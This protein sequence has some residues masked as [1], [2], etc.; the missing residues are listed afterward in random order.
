MPQKT[1]LIT[2]CSKGG[3]GEAM[4]KAYQARG[5]RVFATLRNK[6]KGKS[7]EGLQ[8]IEILELDVTSEES[9]R[10]CAETVKKLTGGSLD[11]LVNNAG[12]AII[13]PLLD[14]SVE[15]AKR[16]YDT[17]VWAVLLMT[18]AFAPMLIKSKGTV[19]NISSVSGELVFAWQET[20]GLEMAPL[21]VR[22]VT[23]VLGGVETT[24]NNPDNRKDLELPP[25][26]FYETI[27]AAIN[28]HQKGLIHINKQNVDMAARNV[29]N[30]TLTGG[31]GFVRRGQ[32]S[33][34]SWWFNTFLSHALTTKFANGE[35]G[36]ADLG[37]K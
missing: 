20:L 7:L 33:S 18:Q 15:E 3:L 16:V 9:V 14:T 28:R 34:L 27:Y 13:M 11:I 17:N 37:G 32:A 5:F 4:A 6:S 23:V 29:V 22:V 25:N 2:G 19:C 35:S 31:A 26:S 1:V 8:D 30:D 24:G 12:I 21:G 10:Q 36:L